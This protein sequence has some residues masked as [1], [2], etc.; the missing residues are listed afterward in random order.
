MA[1]T[2]EILADILERWGVDHLYGMPGDSINEFVEELRKAR[3]ELRF[4]QVR[5]EEVGAL[6]AGAYAKLTGKIGVC[7]SI[8]GP[9][10]IHL[11]NG[12]YDAKADGAPVLVI[13]GQVHSTQIGTD[14]FQ[15]INLER[16]FDDAAVFNKRVQS[17]EQLPD[18]LNQ[19]I[20]TA[21]AEK[22]PAVLIV[23]DDL[24]AEKAEWDQPLTSDILAETTGFPDQKDMKLAAEMI[25]RAKKPVI[26]AGKGALGAKEELALFAEK[27]GA[28]VAVSLPGKGA[29]SDTHPLSLGHIGQ[30]GTKQSYWAM[31]ETDLLIMIGTSFP[32]REFLPEKAD[33]IQIDLET[34]FIGKRYPVACG[35]NGDAKKV[36]ESLIPSVSYKKDRKFLEDSKKRI[37][38]WRKEIEKDKELET[39]KLM[40]PQVMAEVQKVLADDAILSVDVGNV[41]VWAARYLDLDRQSML[42]SSWL[43]TMGCGLPGAISAKVAE[44][45]KQVWALCGDGGFT[46][47]MQD[48]VTAV[49]YKLPFV[50]VIFNNQK[51]GMIHY[52]QQQMGHIEYGTELG[53][54]DFAAF[55]EACGG[56]GVRIE[57]RDEMRMALKQALHADRP[58]I[59]DV[60][61][62]EEPPLPGNISYDQAIHYRFSERESPFL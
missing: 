42:L 56:I 36:L 25:D 41:T 24:F 38:S 31:Q 30:I 51:L 6:A 9:G 4:Y 59:L 61:I 48:F 23:P 33:A 43:A 39:D 8:A 3:N 1:R 53:S 2:G 10:A 14:A 54:I 44:P 5:H 17:H 45:E 15:E 7:L 34:K 28:P 21:Y 35:L 57:S 46:M 55:A 16:M 37:E 62:Q 60:Q 40:P 13:A 20:R 52:E 22:G 32:Y 29:I 26:L 27:I 18:L 47:V 49:R 50:T 58:V 12:L 19:A 11:L